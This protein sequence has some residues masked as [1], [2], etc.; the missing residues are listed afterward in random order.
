MKLK[1]FTKIFMLIMIF[2]YY[3]SSFANYNSQI[4]YIDEL[5]KKDKKIIKADKEPS[6]P[7]YQGDMLNFDRLS[8]VKN[9]FDLNHELPFS[10]KKLEE[11]PQQKI[12]KLETVRSKTVAPPPQLQ[13]IISSKE[14]ATELQKY[15]LDTYVFDGVINQGNSQWAIIESSQENL[16]LYAK[17]GQLIGQNYGRI[18]TINT[19]EM[20]VSQWKKDEKTGVWKNLQVNIKAK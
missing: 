6:I 17:K 19:D 13:K 18:D 8:H 4:K 15:P 12:N 5:I 3:Q 20:I 16:L 10:K 1:L 2:L 9:I 7:N 11:K 14:K